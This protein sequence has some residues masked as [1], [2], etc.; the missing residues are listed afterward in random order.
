MCARTRSYKW[1]HCTVCPQWNG[2]SQLSNKGKSQTPGHEHQALQNGK[3][4]TEMAKSWSAEQKKMEQKESG[5]SKRLSLVCSERAITVVW[6][7]SSRWQASS[8][9]PHRQRRMA[10]KGICSSARTIEGHNHVIAPASKAEELQD[11]ADSQRVFVWETFTVTEKINREHR[12]GLQCVLKCDC[13]KCVCVQRKDCAPSKLSC[14]LS[15]RCRDVCHTRM[16]S[17]SGLGWD[18]VKILVGP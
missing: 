12:K 8:I 1:L 6:W 11:L 18:P 3:N 14:S 17:V 15:K 10:E 2:K 16:R 7:Q 5:L 4:K 13:V 9:M